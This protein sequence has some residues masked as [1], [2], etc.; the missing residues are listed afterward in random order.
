MSK[1]KIVLPEPR[2]MR[3]IVMTYNR[4]R[5]LQKC[6]DSV[7]ALRLDGD[8]AQ[9]EV[10]IGKYFN[11]LNNDVTQIIVAGCNKDP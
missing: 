2:K 9:L 5:S 3:I 4:A 7:Q 1:L 11:L 8:T 6:L 10:W